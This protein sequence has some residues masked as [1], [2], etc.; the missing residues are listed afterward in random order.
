M[1]PA[2]PPVVDPKQCVIPVGHQRAVLGAGCPW[3]DRP[4]SAG[5][6]G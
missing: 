6:K 3:I 1:F 2:V 5:F 4:Q